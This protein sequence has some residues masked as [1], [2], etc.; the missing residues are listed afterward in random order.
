MPP[1]GWKWVT[2][3]GMCIAGS[4]VG[5]YFKVVPSEVPVGVIM[6]VIGLFARSPLAEKKT[7]P[8]EGDKK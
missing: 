7:L 2:L 5:A 4:L 1:N 3:A 6:S 8:G